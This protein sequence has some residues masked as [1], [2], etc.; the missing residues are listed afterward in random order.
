MQVE[1]QGSLKEQIYSDVQRL[2]ES[3]GE[4]PEPI[5]KPFLI[6]I[7]GLPGTGKSYFSRRLTER[8]SCV[9]LESD[10]LRKTLFPSPGYSAGESKRLFSALHKL[11]EEL[12]QQNIPVLLDATNLIEH[13]REK[14]YHIADRLEVK[15]ILVRV[16]APAEVVQ[17]RLQARSDGQDDSS[18][19]DFSI[20][21]R[22]K[23]RAQRIRRQHF[24]VDTS[25]DI[26]PVIEKI[27]R[28]AKRT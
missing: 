21:Q 16:E 7:S 12:L 11:I 18:D 26:S 28:E 27:V 1:T 20:Y 4:L 2:K 14:L 5:V 15:L 8:L 13:H 17:E 24:A 19:A 22:M 25:K 10:E 9:R 3:L 6:L 23:Q